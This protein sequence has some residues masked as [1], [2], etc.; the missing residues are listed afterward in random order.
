MPT[1]SIRASQEER[2]EIDRRARACG[3]TRSTFMLD[4][5]LERCTEDH[6]RF[7]QLER[8]LERLEA[9]RCG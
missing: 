4:V 6:E 7:D 9:D 1:I 3:V 2:A 5:A 8:R